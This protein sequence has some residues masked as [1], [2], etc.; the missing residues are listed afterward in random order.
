MTF[1]KPEGVSEIPVVNNG[2]VTYDYVLKL[3]NKSVEIRY[4]VRPIP[5]E[6]FALYENRQKKEG[7]TVLN[8][9]KIHRMLTPMMYSSI[10]EGKITK[11]KIV[12]QYFKPGRIK[13]SAGADFGSMSSGPLGSVW[14]QSY[15]F[16]FYV[17]M[18]K[19]Y[20]ADAYVFYLF[21][22]EKQMEEAFKELTTNNALFY[23][24]K[25]K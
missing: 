9:N 2:K 14:A 16:G 15:T 13:A 19:D 11:E 1:V 10:S 21:E 12:I 8:P 7:D 24:L 20:L 25:F 4:A 18:H 6:I 5:S 3:N 22:D 17:M 23:A